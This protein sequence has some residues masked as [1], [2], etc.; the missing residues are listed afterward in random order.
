[1]LEAGC[2]VGNCLFP[3]LEE[4]LNIFAYAC[5]FSPRAVEYVKVSAPSWYFMIVLL[6]LFDLP[7]I[8]ICPIP[9]RSLK[10]ISCDHHKHVIVFLF[11]YIYN[12]YRNSFI[13]KSRNT[14][15]PDLMIYSILPHLFYRLFSLLNHFKVNYRHF[16]AKY[17]CIHLQ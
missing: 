9:D 11:A 12:T 1:M 7:S 17:V 2:G 16:T 4:D 5:D 6:D 10:L 3:L 13:Q 8:P 14:I 15:Y